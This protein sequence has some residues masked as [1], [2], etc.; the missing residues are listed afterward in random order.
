MSRYRAARVRPRIVHLTT[1]DISLSLL[2]GPQ[3][4]AFAAA[5]YEIVGVS[6]PGPHVAE[7]ESWGIA[8]HALDSLTR[9]M[10]P[11][12]DV[13]ALVEL[14]SLFRELRPDLVHTHNPKTGVYGRLAARAASVPAVVNTVHGLYALPDDPIAKRALVYGLERIAATCSD[15]ELIQ[16]PEDV[17]T[18]R[19]LRVPERKLHLLGNGIDLHRF[20]PAGVDAARRTELRASFGAGPDDVVCG[21][22]G[23]LVW[24]KGYR[25]VFAAAERLRS[26]APQVKVVVVGPTEEAKSDA[27]DPD[28]I[29]R[30]ER[31]GGIT[32]LGMR[33]DLDDLYGAM[34]LYVLA[35]YREGWPRSAME[36]AAMRLPVV[37]TDIRGCRQVVE[38]GTTGFLVPVRDA[39]AM[40]RAVANLASDPGLRADMG[41]AARRKAEQEFDDQRIIDITLEVYARLLGPR[42]PTVAA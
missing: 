33:D 8:H 15:A 36:A 25:E 23:R 34:D 28:A 13:R 16:N 39:D 5:G 22:V 6:G 21:V 27:V 18:L 9:S 29:A 38:H 32:F 7:L 31:D 10:A 41:A 3:L 11:H 1:S 12:R 24:E 42:R 30:A 26:L 37:V 14:R 4:R 35:S 20:D 2:L 19:E 17:E 40:A